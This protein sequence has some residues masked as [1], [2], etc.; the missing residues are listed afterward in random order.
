[1]N[2][3]G[4]YSCE[5]SSMSPKSY[6]RICQLSYAPFYLVQCISVIKKTVFRV[7]FIPYLPLQ[8]IYERV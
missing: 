6:V 3:V 1:M 8:L 4:D 5:K 7:S 2:K